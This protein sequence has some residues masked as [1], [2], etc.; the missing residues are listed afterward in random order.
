MEHKECEL[1]EIKADGEAGEFTAL[2]SV[3]NNVDHVGDRVMP[4][5]FTDTLRKWR[6]K[7]DPIPVVLAHQWNDPFAHVGYADPKNAKQTKKGLE[8][9]GRLDIHD[10]DVA[11]QTYKLMR[12]RRLTNFSFG[13]T[14]PEGGQRMA[15]GVNEV[16]AVDLIEIGPCLKG[17]NPQAHLQGIKS[18]LGTAK[19]PDDEA[20][21]RRRAEQVDHEMIAEKLSDTPPPKPEPE[22]TP[23]ELLRLALEKVDDTD[24]AREALL[25]HFG[26]VRAKE[27]PE[28]GTLRKRAGR[29]ER[30]MVA[31]NLPSEAPPSPEPEPTALD[32]LHSALGKAGDDDGDFRQVLLEHF[33]EIRAKEVPEEGV[34]RKRADRLEREQI[35]DV[36]PP[37]LP[38]DEREEYK[39]IL[40]SL[41]VSD[42]MELVKSVLDAEEEQDIYLLPADE[43]VEYK[44]I[45]DVLQED[46]DK[47]DAVLDAVLETSAVEDGTHKEPEK[48]TSRPQDPL[49]QRSMETVLEIH[50][51]GL[52]P[53]RPPEVKEEPQARPA[54]VLKRLSRDLELEILTQGVSNDTQ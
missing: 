47:M 14:V 25:E 20:T 30:E 12:E 34:L 52:P 49:Y 23:L 51:D 17:A 44:T 3:F 29:I 48:A 27:V 16:K 8:V 41:R 33:G 37:A 11:R 43:R 39:A 10:N 26:E 22:P 9:K 31:E 1:I 32:L 53:R 35:A 13:Y 21:L 5:A 42:R 19:A 54:D 46:P 28:E 45:F 18:A 36:L 40:D 50:S 38:S 7:G 2:V 4:G 24:E 6:A 15:D